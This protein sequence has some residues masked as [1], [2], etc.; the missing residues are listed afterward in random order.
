MSS[1]FI[2]ALIL[3]VYAIV[4][5]V[6]SARLKWY[7]SILWIVVVVAFGLKYV[8]YSQTGGILEPQL[9]AWQIVV[10]E[11]TYS[12][13]MLAVFL[14]IVKDLLLLVRTIFRF[15]AKIPKENRRPWPLGRINAI[16]A[17][18]ALS[19]GVGGTVYQYKVPEIATV[20]IAVNDLAPELRDYKI[21]Q[22]T[23]LHIGPILKRDWLEGVV[24][25]VN[26]Q[27]PDLVV[28]TGDF[29]DGSVGK[30][31]DEFL[32]LANLKAKDGVLAVTGNHEYYSGANSWVSTLENLGV[33]FLKNQSVL[34]KAQG[35]TTDRAA[36]LVS[37]VPDPRG[38]AF[39]EDDPDVEAAFANLVARKFV[40]EDPQDRAKA[41]A[42]LA[43]AAAAQKAAAAKSVNA[44]AEVALNDINALQDE[45]I[46]TTIDATGQS[47]EDAS[48]EAI[49][50]ISGISISNEE[51]A[52][53][54][55][56]AQE[57][58]KNSIPSV[59]DAA[60]ASFKLLLAHEPVVMTQNPDVNLVLTGHTHGGTMF[61]LKPLIAAF[62]AGYVSGLYEVTPDTSIYVSNG[63][64]IWSGFSCRV[65]VPSE[66]TVFNLKTKH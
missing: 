66:I 8:V 6:L 13:L 10:L 27:D 59:S 37:G 61:F 7:Q 65:L 28:I 60:A 19:F 38:Q 26:E 45:A 23:D 25:R 64:G 48:N 14:A 47:N 50:H 53:T 22:L 20:D 63:T 35:A 33:Q 51:D 16:I 49:A 43:A 55:A 4:S 58:R 62:N 5:L 39:G 15:V 44:D 57:R 9:P 41:K 1:L 34:I 18:V 52:A 36:I 2:S 32:P 17:V 24:Q 46:R 31:K 21:V 54:A 29:V 40:P 42:D 12:A 11:A 56:V 30:L 3:V